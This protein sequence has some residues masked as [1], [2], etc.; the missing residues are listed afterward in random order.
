ML[1]RGVIFPFKIKWDSA[2]ILFEEKPTMR[3]ELHS[4]TTLYIEACLSNRS[5][6]CPSNNHVGSEL[7]Q[8]A[9]CIFD[10]QLMQ[11]CRDTVTQA[12]WGLP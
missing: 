12:K 11:L 5:E 4:G 10:R 1:E 9:T 7:G 3:M 6:Y 2:S 8:P